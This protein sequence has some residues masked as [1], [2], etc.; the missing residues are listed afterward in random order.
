MHDSRHHQDGEAVVGVESA[1]HVP[2]EQRTLQRLHTVGPTGLLLID[3]QKLLHIMLPE[4]SL[5]HF[6]KIR[7]YP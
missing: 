3:R 1:E 7:F 6:L 4:R 2:R 5:G